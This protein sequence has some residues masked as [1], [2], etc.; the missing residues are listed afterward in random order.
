MRNSFTLIELL[1]VVAI[2][3]I[4]AAIAMPNF[5]NAQVRAKVA[6]AVSNMKSVQSAL[7]SYYLD[8]GSYPRW[9]WDGWG[10]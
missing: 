2:I 9:A 1:I 3:G 5:L 7:E 10:N 8:I 6:R 4:L